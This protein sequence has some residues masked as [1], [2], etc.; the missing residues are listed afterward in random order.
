MFW[1]HHSLLGSTMGNAREF[2]EIVRLLGAGKLRPVV[3][4]VTPLTEARRALE[5]LAAGEHFGKLVLD[6]AA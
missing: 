2:A 6:I 4:S 1:Y 5:R 3:D